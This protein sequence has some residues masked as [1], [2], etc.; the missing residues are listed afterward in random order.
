M[1]EKIAGKMV[2]SGT[3][4]AEDKEIYEFGL[5]YAA[6]IFLNLATTLGIGFVFGMVWQ[7]ALFTAAYIPLRSYAGGYHARTPLRCY[8]FS[9][10]LTVCVLLGMKY[11]PYNNVL[12]L[13]AAFVSGTIIF[14]LA[15]VGDE[16]KPLDEIETRVF[17]KRTRIVLFAETGLICVLLVLN[18]AFAAVCVVV[19]VSIVSLMVVLGKLKSMKQ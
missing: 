10:V 6:N 13:S 5:K 3:I 4:N 8:I 19:S 2:E 17:K 12:L 1:V 9:V 16:N 11:L 15:P 18:L 7:S 14:M